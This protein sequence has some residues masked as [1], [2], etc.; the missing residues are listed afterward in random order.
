MTWLILMKEEL[1][2]DW[3]QPDLF[4]IGASSLLADIE[5]QL[6]HFVTGRYASFD[7]H[8]HGL[9]NH[10]M[11][12][13]EILDT[14]DYGPAPESDDAGRAWL[15]RHDGRLRPFHRRRSCAKP[16]ADGCFDVDRPGDR[17]SCL[18]GSREAGGRT[19]TRPSRRRARRQVLVGAAAGPRA[20][21]ATSMPS[22]A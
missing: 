5:R 15:K 17:R 6:E 19:S 14:M 2:N 11:S 8:A 3:L 1:G 21:Q 18:P 12:I 7:R 10:V 9:R 4:R 13:A 20:R 16:G 22:P